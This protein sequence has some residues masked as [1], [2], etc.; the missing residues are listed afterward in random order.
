M[1]LIDGGE[2]IACSCIGGAAI[3][4]NVRNI[5]MSANVSLTL[6][7]TGANG[8]A[9]ESIAPSNGTLVASSNV[10]R[11]FASEPAKN[12][13][14]DISLLYSVVAPTPMEVL[15]GVPA[16]EIGSLLFPID[17]VWSVVI[18]ATQSWWTKRIDIDSAVVRRVFITLGPSGDYT[19][20]A[21]SGSY[22]GYLV[23]GEQETFQILGTTH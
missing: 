15:S 6:L 18:T 5:S 23:S 8:T 7:S 1:I 14:V 20:T 22:K 3:G 2:V 13:L 17:L 4:T 12:G 19:I 21:S 16:I 11:V 9:A 10:S